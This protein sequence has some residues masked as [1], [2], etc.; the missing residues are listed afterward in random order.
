M[1]KERERE[2]RGKRERER[3][4]WGCADIFS[5][6]GQ[7]AAEEEEEKE[8]EEEDEEVQGRDCGPIAAGPCPE[9]HA[10]CRRGCRPGHGTPPPQNTHSS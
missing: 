7:A 5:L 9:L 8:D 1:P 6:S 2:E 4:R 3:D 10:V